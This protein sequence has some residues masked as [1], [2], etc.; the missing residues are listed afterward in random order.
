MIA[1]G[2]G[3]IYIIIAMKEAK[4]V[5][6]AIDFSSDR[7]TWDGKIQVLLRVCGKIPV[8]SG[9]TA[10]YY[11]IPTAKVKEGL[12]ELERLRETENVLSSAQTYWNKWLEKGLKPKFPSRKFQSYYEAN[13]L[14]LKAVN[15]GGAI[16]G[17]LAGQF[18]AGKSSMFAPRDS[19]MTARAFILAGYVEEA[20]KI[21]D[22]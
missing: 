9:F 19:M 21:L 5:K 16:P 14:S 13:L 12:K 1:E 6:R 11:L 7:E 17:D 8:N 10:E 2:A 3:D 22:Y 18:V 20:L 4:P 15:L